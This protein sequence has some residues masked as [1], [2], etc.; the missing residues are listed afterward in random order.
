MNLLTDLMRAREILERGRSTGAFARYA[1]GIPCGWGD[2]HAELF[3]MA[4]ACHRAVDERLPR[5]REN[6][7]AYRACLVALEAFTRPHDSVHTF[8]DFAT[9]SEALH[10]FSLAIGGLRHDLRSAA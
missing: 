10:V 4:G 5:T 9:D 2:P 1:N 3:D 8:N 6:T 7:R